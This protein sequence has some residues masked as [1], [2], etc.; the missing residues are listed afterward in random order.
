MEAQRVERVARPLHH[1]DQAFSTSA[2]GH[3]HHSVPAL[4]TGVTRTQRLVAA[5]TYAAAAVPFHLAYGT[6]TSTIVATLVALVVA[7]VMSALTRRWPLTPYGIALA[8]V[9][10][11]LAYGTGVGPALVGV[12][13]AVAGAVRKRA[14]HVE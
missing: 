2:R 4:G 9:G 3:Y 6:T 5:L 11:P 14:S 13:V 1:G 7:L 10:V 12:V 8:M